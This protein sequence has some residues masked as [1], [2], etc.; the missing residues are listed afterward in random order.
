MNRRIVL[1][2][3]V[4]LGPLLIVAALSIQ[5]TAMASRKV[6]VSRAKAEPSHGVFPSFVEGER[7]DWAIRNT[8]SQAVSA[9][10]CAVQDERGT[11]V[12]SFH[13]LGEAEAGKST[14]LYFYLPLGSHPRSLRMRVLEKASVIGKSRVALQLLIEKAAGRYKGKQVWFPE[15]RIP[16]YECIVNVDR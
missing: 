16:A 3:S 12:P 6:T 4:S 1:V 14:Q 10:I 13:P 9:E 5:T 15:L 8:G 2:G 7:L 11:W